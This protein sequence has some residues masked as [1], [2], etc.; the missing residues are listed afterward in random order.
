MIALAG[1]AAQRIH[2][3]RSFRNF[4][5][6]SDHRTAVDISGIVNESPEQAQAWLKWLEIRTRDDINLLWPIVERLADNL[7]RMETLKADQI[8]A[9]ITSTEATLSVTRSKLR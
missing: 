2:A 6:S 8:R 9:I 3:P 7:L 5:A 1:P 4:H